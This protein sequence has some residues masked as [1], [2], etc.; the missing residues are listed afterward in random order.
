MA[1]KKLIVDDQFSYHVTNR[2]N[3]QEWFYLPIGD[4]WDIFQVMLL[5]TQEIYCL[6][7][8]SLVLMSNHFHLH[9]STP[10]KNLHL[11]MRYFQ[12]EV[13]RRI[14][15]RTGRKNHIF[16]TRYRWSWLDSGYATAYASK[17]VLRNPVR[18]GIVDRVEQYEFSTLT[19]L[20]EGKCRLPITDG[21]RPHWKFIPNHIED[22][23]RWLNSPTP[24]ELE[25]LVG[26]ALRRKE[27]RFSRGNEIRL[28]LDQL[29][30]QYQI[31]ITP[32]YFSAEK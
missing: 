11:A 15:K 31:P 17:Y 23:L 16:G 9:L 25:E 26:K 10:L 13:A 20:L 12:T 30:Q 6:E 28:Q 5:R 14:Q 21:V 4:I 7:I 1:R 24:K 8:H 19:Q 22:R 2:S 27:F 3:N 32:G 29:A 18:A